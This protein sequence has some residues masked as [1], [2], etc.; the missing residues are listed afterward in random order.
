M[1][2]THALH[3]LPSHLRTYDV[4]HLAT[5]PS[6][7]GRCF[8]CWRDFNTRYE[9]MDREEVPCAPVRIKPCGHLI[10]DQCLENLFLHGITDC[11]I[12]RRQINI[13]HEG[14]PRWLKTLVEYPVFFY[15]SAS[16]HAR[17]ETARFG[18]LRSYSKRLS[19]LFRGKLG[20]ADAVCLWCQHMA[21]LLPRLRTICLF[22]M[23]NAFFV[24]PHV[25]VDRLLDVRGTPVEPVL[26]TGGS[27]SLYLDKAH[28]IATLAA[29]AI[30]VLAYYSAAVGLT[31]WNWGEWLELPGDLPPLVQILRSMACMEIS[32]YWF[33]VRGLVVVQL[34]GAMWYAG[35]SAALIW[36]GMKGTGAVRRKQA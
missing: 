28:H 26:P 1:E 18:Q 10:G 8:N 34:V 35:T 30:M 12:C 7:A 21:G 27:S 6:D 24:I 4:E 33:G 17:K 5:L 36:Y 15:V 25:I 2:E 22:A 13:N 32:L 31:I 23:L 29:S 19:D 11:Q 9:D 16:H 20:Y 14:I 3:N